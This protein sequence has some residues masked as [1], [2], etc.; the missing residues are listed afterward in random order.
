[1]ENNQALA[2]GG[3]APAVI[4]IEYFGRAADDAERLRAALDQGPLRVTEV[5]E[6]GAGQVHMGAAEIVITVV[7]AAAAKAVASTALA[8]LE[9]YIRRQIEAKK[10]PPD[11]VAVVKRK[12]DGKTIDR[13][14][15]SFG[16]MGL[17]MVAAFSK[18]LR[19]ALDKL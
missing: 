17:E 1:M 7:V 12:D 11:L 19:G 15:F 6:R 8:H 10:S 13:V 2:P 3:D 5:R 9:D 4:S 16:T 14:P 18:N